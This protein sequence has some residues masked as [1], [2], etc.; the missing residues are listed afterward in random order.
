MDLLNRVKKIPDFTQENSECRKTM[1]QFFSQA[2]SDEWKII[3]ALGYI[4]FKAN[5][6]NSGFVCGCLWG[7]KE[8]VKGLK[9][10][11]KEESETEYLFISS[12]MKD[13][14]KFHDVA[15][16]QKNDTILIIIS[17]VLSL[18]M[19]VFFD[20]YINSDHDE[21]YVFYEELIVICKIKNVQVDEF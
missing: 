15:V 1:M 16:E 13:I 21:D 20:I 3:F 6:E 17:N 8:Y 19:V 5:P 18:F 4:L 14:R 10:S 12:L 11:N 9:L 2:Q 7:I